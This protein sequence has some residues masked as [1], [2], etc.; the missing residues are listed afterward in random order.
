MKTLS[1]F[2]LLVMFGICNVF[3]QQALLDVEGNVKIIG[4]I[5][6]Y[7]VEDTST[8]YVGRNAGEK[9]T[10]NTNPF[11]VTGHNTFVGSNAGTE[12]TS[13]NGNS[14]FGESAG[15]R[16]TTGIS[17]TFIGNIAGLNNTTGRFNTYLGW[18][19]GQTDQSVSLN[20]AIAIGYNAQ[21]G[22]EN[23]AV[24]GGFGVD[25]VNVGIGTE[26]PEKLLDVRGESQFLGTTTV[27]T[28][29][30]ESVLLNLN[31]DRNW[32]FRQGGSG[33]ATSL[34]L[35]SVGG[36]GN[37]NFVINTSGDVGIGLLIPTHPL[38]LA[39]GAHVTTGGVWTNASSKT[40]KENIY[41][42][43]LEEAIITLA[44]LVPVKFNYLLQKDE[45][46]VGFLAEDV[47][48]LVA[49][50]DRKSLSSMDIVAVLTRVVQEQQSEI[51]ELKERVSEIDAFKQEM[52]ELKSLLKSQTKIA[53]ED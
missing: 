16:T 8:V 53:S 21:V 18:G 4:N 2:L 30:F 7:H 10:F 14:F 28:P 11:D 19:A 25:A 20:K 36:G 39:S 33:S 6:I 52:A 43:T 24:I 17:N 27:G 9:T 50:Q 42:L 5:E 13:G 32:T 31:S 35:E 12:N 23:C 47:P 49:T 34:V 41:N 22:C 45:V 26:F 44:E 1:P 38:H 51:S 29:G 48:E 40:L 37:K 15:R 46:Y 3:S